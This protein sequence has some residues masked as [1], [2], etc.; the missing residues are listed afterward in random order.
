MG[1]LERASTARAGD[2]RNGRTSLETQHAI[3]ALCSVRKRLLTGVE[4][5]DAIEHGS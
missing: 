4:A 1:W 3:S 2:G 5:V